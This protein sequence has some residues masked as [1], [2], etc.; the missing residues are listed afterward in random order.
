MDIATLI[1]WVLTAG[2]GF[3]MLSIWISRGGPGA[4]RS[5]TQLPPPVLFSH[6]GLAAAGLVLW[7]AYVFTGAAALAWLAVAL[8]VAVA[9]LGFLM[10][11]RWRKTRAGTAAAAGPGAAPADLPEQHFPVP[12]VAAH[13]VAAVV[14][15]VLAVLVAVGV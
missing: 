5:E 1:A 12:V 6:F 13:G 10:F 4:R 7:V 3:F 14:T 9:I 15:L 8:L 2:G 11:A